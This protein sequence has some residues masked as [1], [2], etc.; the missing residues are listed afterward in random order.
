MKSLFRPISFNIVLQACFGKE[1][2]SL[3]DPFWLKW[4][5]QSKKNIKKMPIQI[6]SHNIP[7]KFI[8]KYGSRAEI[9]KLL[10]FDVNSIK[11]LILKFKNN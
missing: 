4:D 9:D 8:E 5:K 3:N 6:I 10:G 2:L 7:K 1:L 11:N